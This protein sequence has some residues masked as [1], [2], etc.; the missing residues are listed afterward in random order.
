MKIVLVILIILCIILTGCSTSYTECKHDCAHVY[1]DK[2]CAEH[3]GDTFGQNRCMDGTTYSYRESC[4][5]TC[6]G[7]IE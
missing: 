7:G 3:G 5:K 4:L 2:I 1:A 6:G